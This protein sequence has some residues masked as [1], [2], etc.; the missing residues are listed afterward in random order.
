MVNFV[1]VLGGG[2]L[3]AV[4]TRDLCRSRVVEVVIGDIGIGRGEHVSFT[5]A[6]ALYAKIN[7]EAA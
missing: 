4:A 2:R 1:F 5:V 6:V 7:P 3:G